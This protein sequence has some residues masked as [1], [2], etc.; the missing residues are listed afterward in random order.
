MIITIINNHT[1]KDNDNNNNDCHN[2]KI[3]IIV[4]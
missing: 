2:M 1:D 4:L 3:V